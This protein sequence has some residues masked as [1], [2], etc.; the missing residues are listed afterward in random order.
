MACRLTTLSIDSRF[1]DQYYDCTGEFL[2]RLPSVM[3]NVSRIALTSVEI[4]QVPYVFSQRC[5]NTAFFFDISGVRTALSIAD[6]TYTADQLAA[7]VTGAIDISG[8]S[9]VYNA[10]NDRFTI[11]N[12]CGTAVVL[13]LSSVNSARGRYWGLGYWLGFRVHSVF[14]GTSASATAPSP[15]ILSPP[16][17]ALVQVQCPDMLDNTIH[18]TDSGSF[19]QALA[20]IVLRP[21]SSGTGSFEIQYDDA[22]NCVTKENVFPSSTAITQLRIRLVDAYGVTVDLADIDWSLTLEVVEVIN[23]LAKC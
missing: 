23:S 10:T 3:R 9:I 1:A 4:P 12:V 14:V 2:I 22:S 7:V 21:G 6:G 20:K 5:G 15:P 11:V 18:R 17:Y 13:T 19:V 16:S 8:V